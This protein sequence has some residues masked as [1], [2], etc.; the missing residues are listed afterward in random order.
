MQNLIQIYHAVQELWAFS[1][2]DHDWPDWCSAKL[3]HQKGMLRMPVVRL[4]MPNMIKI[5]HVVQELWVFSPT[6][7]GRTDGQIDRHTYIHTDRR[8]DGR[9]DGQTDS[10]SDFSAHLQLKHAGVPTV[11]Y[12]FRDVSI[13][14]RRVNTFNTLKFPW[15]TPVTRLVSTRRVPI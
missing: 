15:C 11:V 8:T 5:Y 2:N 14:A 12:Q 13:T 10:H 1:L 3:V 6:A 4:L 9:T 7:N